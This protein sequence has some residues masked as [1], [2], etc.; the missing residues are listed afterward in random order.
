MTSNP[1][2]VS[3]PRRARSLRALVPGLMTIG[4]MVVFGGLWVFRWV[5]AGVSV[6]GLLVLVG[7]LVYV[8]WVLAEARVSVR[9]LTAAGPTYDRNTLELAAFAKQALLLAALLPPSHTG[10]INGSIGIAMIAIGGGFRILAIRRMGERYTHRI[11]M[12][13]DGIVS[14]GPYRIVRH[15]AYLGTLIGHAGI[16]VLLLS[17]WSVAVFALAWLP[18]V[19]ARTL[20]EDG[21]LRNGEPGYPDYCSQVRWR[22]VPG[23]W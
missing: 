13:A 21:V 12:P 5:T 15:P 18:I 22:L 3:P 20:L 17:P 8:S 19:V 11:R 10:W 1:E 4:G 6:Q 2:S 16:A 14:S 9:E 23:A 7:G